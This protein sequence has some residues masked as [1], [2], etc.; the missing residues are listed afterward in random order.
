MIGIGARFYVIS[1][2]FVRNVNVKRWLS[3]IAGILK[4]VGILRLIFDVMQALIQIVVI[5]NLF[6]GELKSL[7]K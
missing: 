3:V 1:K 6:E 2:T 5:Q 4:D 7:N